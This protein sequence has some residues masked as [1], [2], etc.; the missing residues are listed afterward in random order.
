MESTIHEESKKRGSSTIGAATIGAVVGAAGVAGV[1]YAMQN[2]K[3]RKV[4]KNIKDKALTEL[5]MRL[6]SQAKLIKKK[7]EPMLDSLQSRTIHKAKA[8]S[9]ANVSGKRKVS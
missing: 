5:K 6:D 8:I 2:P 7:T 9:P 3:I 1:A 4:A